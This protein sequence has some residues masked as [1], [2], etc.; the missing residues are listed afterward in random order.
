MGEY[1]KE[2]SIEIIVTELLIIKGKSD[3]VNNPGY[4]NVIWCIEDIP[5][6]NAVMRHQESPN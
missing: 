4:Y 6:K 5:A 3:F 1:D 2:L